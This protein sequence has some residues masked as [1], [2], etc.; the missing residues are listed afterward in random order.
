M[1]LYPRIFAALLAA[2]LF[3][4]GFG[5]RAEMKVA[6]IDVERAV[7]QTEDG[8]RAQASLKK[9]FDAK[10]QELNKKQADLQKQ[11]EELEKQQKVLSKEAF[12]KRVEDWQK[13]MVE[14][15]SVFVEYNKDLEKKQ[16]ELTEPI[17]EKLMAIVKR[18][19]AAEGFDIVVHKQ[20]AAYMRSDLDLTDRVI[21]QYNGG[22]GGAAKPA[23][24]AAP[25]K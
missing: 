22:G 5:A 11:R 15:Q 20:A 13:A 16:K 24:P 10:Q 18:I 6:V 8:L 7:M 2:S 12:Q 14:L 3:L 9:I 23:A 19:A 17:A 25:K 1:K 4:L 21:Q